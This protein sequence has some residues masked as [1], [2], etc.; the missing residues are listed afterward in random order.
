MEF[1]YL[2]KLEKEEAL[3]ESAYDFCDELT[4]EQ[5]EELRE[6]AEF[7]EYVKMIKSYN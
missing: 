4:E 3:G 7:E 2:S 6:K 1:K 5:E